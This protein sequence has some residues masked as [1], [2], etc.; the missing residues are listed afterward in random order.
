MMIWWLI[1]LVGAAYFFRRYP[2]LRK[3]WYWPPKKGLVALM[4]HHIGILENPT[5][6]QYPFTIT[7]QH[8]EAQLQYLKN[9]GYTPISLADLQR[10][11]CSLLTTAMPTTLPPFSL[12]CKSTARRR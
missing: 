3:T 7:P 4:Y 1:F 6:E 9:N 12:F 11:L 5:D 2:A 10:A 8:F